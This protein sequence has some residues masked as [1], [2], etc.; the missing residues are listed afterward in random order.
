MFP[1]PSPPSPPRTMA[2]TMSVTRILVGISAIR[3]HVLSHDLPAQVS[4]DFVDIGSPTSTCLVVRS[5][6]PALTDL[7][8][9]CPRHGPVIFEIRL[10]PDQDDGHV[11]GVFDPHDLVA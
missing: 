2:M 1:L 6:A 8:G 10:V 5:I 7:K 3:L 4:E 9:T 11:G